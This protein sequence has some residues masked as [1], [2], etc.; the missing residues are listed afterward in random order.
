MFNP[1][2]QNKEITISEELINKG[3]QSAKNWPPCLTHNHIIHSSDIEEETQL[4]KDYFNL[5]KISF[6]LNGN[7]YLGV[8]KTIKE[9]NISDIVCNIVDDDCKTIKKWISVID[10]PHYKYL[11]GK[12]LSM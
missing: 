5:N 4:V 1:K 9:I 2:S 6:N 8:K 3:I 12:R 7:N 11:L 10:T